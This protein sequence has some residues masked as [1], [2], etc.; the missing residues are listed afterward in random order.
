LFDW[1]WSSESDDSGDTRNF[2]GDG[3][4]E[5]DWW[6]LDLKLANFGLTEE[7]V[8]VAPSSSLDN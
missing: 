6:F 3:W 2:A 1:E 7:G 8:G 5:L 4:L